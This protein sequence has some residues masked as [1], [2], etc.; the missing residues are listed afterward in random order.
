MPC[1]LSIVVPVYNE[2]QTLPRF[3]DRMR[4]ALLPVTQDYEIIFA[5]DPC[6]DGT[7][8]LIRQEHARDP[9]I[10]LLVFSRRLPV[11]DLISHRFPLERFTEA[12]A[13]ASHPAGDSLKVV[14]LP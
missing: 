12:L 1:L 4:A 9:R 3:L 5:A 14:V 7:V 11:R 8:D 13:L 10:K 2:Q 6:T